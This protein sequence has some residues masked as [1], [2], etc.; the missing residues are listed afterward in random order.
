[1]STP[2]PF[3]RRS[4][5]KGCRPLFFAPARLGPVP[6]SASLMFSGP[7]SGVVHFFFFFSPHFGSDA[8]F[9]G[10]QDNFFLFFLSS[11]RAAIAR[12]CRKS[13]QA[14]SEACKKDIFRVSI[15]ANFFFYLL[16]LLCPPSSSWFESGSLPVPLFGALLFFPLFPCVV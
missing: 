8:N 3:I 10:T 14:P 15:L 6:S 16:D 13:K 5:S 11:K 1:V 12:S 7:R 9:A 2:S 4:G